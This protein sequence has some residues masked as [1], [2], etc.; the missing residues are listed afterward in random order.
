MS[1][2]GPHTIVSFDSVSDAFAFSQ[3]AREAGV[4]GRLRT[5]PRQI[6]AGCGTAWDSPAGWRPRIEALIA[7][8]RL[9]V[10]AVHSL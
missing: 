10:G 2:T 4:E 1:R 9:E 6:S 3:A 5:I 7:E 8:R